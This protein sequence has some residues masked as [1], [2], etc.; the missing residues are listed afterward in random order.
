VTVDVAAW[1]ADERAVVDAALDRLLP[2][3]D[4][5]PVRLHE[6]MRY[7]GFGGGKRVRPILA[8]AACRAAGGDPARALEP[9]CALELIH[10]YSLVHD[11]LPA[12]DDDRLRRGRPTVHV[13]YDEALAILA[14]DALLTEGFAVLARFPE[15]DDFAPVRAEACRVVAAAAGSL[16]MVGGQVEDLEAT[17]A[18]PD[19]ARLERIHRAKTGALL[20]AAVELGALIGGAEDERRQEFA[21][22][23]RG[24]GLLFQI[25]DDILDVTG[26][27]ASLGKSPG[28]DAAAGKLTYPA[29]Y[30]LEA[31]RGRLAELAAEL[32]R[33][34]VRLEGAGGVLDGLVAYVAR[35]DR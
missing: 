28:K 21:D 33:T 25:A 3:A 27:A 8:R 20:A 1:L 10:T 6:A 32:S 2:A 18:A 12:L 15:G 5:W 26:T 29:V 7:A 16:G 4:A 30:G 17:G 35:R 13:A 19:A 31:A 14:G 23:G 34:A 9:G 11:D 22:F 24:L